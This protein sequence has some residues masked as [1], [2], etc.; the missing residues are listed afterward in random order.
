MQLF[1]AFAELR[2]ARSASRGPSPMPRQ[3][4]SFDTEVCSDIC[5]SDMVPLPKASWAAPGRCP[6]PVDALADADLPQSVAEAQRIP[7]ARRNALGSSLL[8]RTTDEVVGKY[9][10]SL[11]GTAHTYAVILFADIVGVPVNPS[12]TGRS[13]AS[14]T[15]VNPLPTPPPDPL[16]LPHDPHHPTAHPSVQ[17]D[18]TQGAA[19]GGV[20]APFVL[21]HIRDPCFTVPGGHLA[22]GQTRADPP[23]RVRIFFL[24]KK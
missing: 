17:E 20:L 23:A 1:R 11:S 6:E 13:T 24:W 18:G 22:S 3:T 9:I 19:V 8:A 21:H 16:H 4:H 14:Q 15:R 7:E 10:A 12:T 2:P 5:P